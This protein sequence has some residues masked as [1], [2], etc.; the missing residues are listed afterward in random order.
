MKTNSSIIALAMVSLLV[1][2]NA[3]ARSYSG[4][5]SDTAKVL[6]AEP[7]YE[8][9]EISRP[10]EE[11]WT[12]E[13]VHNRSYG[14]SYTGTILGGVIGGVVGNQFGRGRG[15]R[16]MTVAGTL[17]GASVGH[18]LNRHRQQRPRV[19]IEERCEIVDRYEQEEQL[20]GYRV[21]YKYRGQTFVTTTQEHPGKR[22]RVRVDVS[23]T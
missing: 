12:E 18:D 14:K 20:V 8:I 13:V 17:L 7:I 2:Q 22:I 3:F 16:A 15:K 5:F 6:W 9:V 21:K 10:V 23:P 11:C 19:T 1:A 4:G